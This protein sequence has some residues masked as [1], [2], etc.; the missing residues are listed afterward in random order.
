MSCW[1]SLCIEPTTDKLAIKKAYA[2]QLKTRK[3]D[4]DPEGFAILH[5]HYKQALKAKPQAIKTSRHQTVVAASTIGTLRTKKEQN[6]SEQL[7]VELSKDEPPIV[8]YIDETLSSE[9]SVNN[10]KT[11]LKVFNELN[12]EIEWRQLKTKIDQVLAFPLTATKNN[13]WSFLDDNEALF[14][15]EFNAYAS[16][17]IFEQLLSLR[18]IITRQ[19]QHAITIILDTFFRWSDRKDLLEAQF[20]YKKVAQLLGNSESD[21]K[22]NA[23]KWSSKKHHHG[24]IIFSSYYRKLAATTIDIGLFAIAQY[25]LMLFTSLIGLEHFLLEYALTRGFIMYLLLAPIL[26]ASTL[27][28]T[29]GKNILNIRVTNL[30]GRRINIFQAYWR[31][32]CFVLSTA[33][34]KLTMWINIFST[35]GKLLHDRFSRSIVIKC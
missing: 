25:F 15:I 22:P 6:I 33:G 9:N 16:S 34:F 30:K 29:P 28:G 18:N 7:K 3:P 11:E 17:Y 13:N 10:Q 8:Q 1:N 19:Q 23:F 4:E 24:P 32:I 35:D 21:N 27:Q 14:D 31:T 5:A 2:N 20:G 26:E 12:F